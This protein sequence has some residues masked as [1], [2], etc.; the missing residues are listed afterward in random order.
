MLDFTCNLLDS[1][2]G[3]AARDAFPSAAADVDFPEVSADMDWSAFVAATMSGVGSKGPADVPVSSCSQILSTTESTATSSQSS[4]ASASAATT[5]AAVPLPKDVVHTPQ[6]PSRERPGQTSR[7]RPRRSFTPVAAN[8]SI[9]RCATTASP[10]KVS[11]G[12]STARLQE[13][14][15]ADQSK[16]ACTAEH[17]MSAMAL[18]L[19]CASSQSS[20]VV[21]AQAFATTM[22]LASRAPLM[23][24]ATEKAKL[25]TSVAGAVEGGFVFKLPPVPR[26]HS[27]GA[28]SWHTDLDSVV[29]PRGQ[30][31]RF[32]S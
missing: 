17:T 20:V 5:Q 19:S 2:L 29:T 30:R 8:A 28:S 14:E 18:D 31:M 23:P 21:P 9:D 10:S 22:Q 32:A 24:K 26:D 6:P 12:R 4:S 25:S 11:P 3:G 7:P 16:N 15:N 1:A 13:A 27:L